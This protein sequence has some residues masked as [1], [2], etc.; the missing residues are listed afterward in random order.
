VAD[1]QAVSV[2]AV[3]YESRI[4]EA[5]PMHLHDFWNA[6]DQMKAMTDVSSFE[7]EPRSHWN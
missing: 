3:S 6:I 4:W 1:C 7:P 2:S 5:K